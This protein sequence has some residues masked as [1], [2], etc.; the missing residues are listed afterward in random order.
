MCGG[1]AAQAVWFVVFSDIAARP[2]GI[3]GLA[4][5]G[6][7]VCFKSL[8]ERTSVCK[9]DCA[10]LDRSCHTN[11]KLKILGVDMKIQVVA[12]LLLLPF[13]SPAQERISKPKPD[14]PK[15]SARVIGELTEATGWMYNAIGEWVSAKNQIPE[16]RDNPLVT[17]GKRQANW[18]LSDNFVSFELR[19]VT[20]WGKNFG[21]LIKR[22][23]SDGLNQKA[24]KTDVLYSIIQLAHLRNLKTLQTKEPVLASFDRIYDAEITAEGNAYLEAIELD[25]FHLVLEYSYADWIKKNTRKNVLLMNVRLYPDKNIAQFIIFEANEHPG[26]VS[27]TNLHF[28]GVCRTTRTISYTKEF[29]TPI[30]LPSIFDRVYYECSYREFMALFG[31]Q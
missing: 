6:T 1:R 10:Y 5:W 27:G 26:L 17:A 28:G 16:D 4:G 8:L 25:L 7:S 20:I 23:K 22:Y 14:K 12:L 21:I 19:E 30:S 2:G 15:I 24:N 31:L 11:S 9:S 13:S 3:Y 18:V 29:I